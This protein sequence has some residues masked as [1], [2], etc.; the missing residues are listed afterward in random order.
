MDIPL[1]RRAFLQLSGVGL[2]ATGGCLGQ[3]EPVPDVTVSNERNEEI[4]LDLTI[5][6]LSDG[7]TMF[8]GEHTLAN[9]ETVT[10]TN[11]IQQA[12]EFRFDVHV[13]G[14]YEDSYDVAFSTDESRGVEL[15]IHDD[16]LEF[17]VVD[18]GWF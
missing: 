5:S 10:I 4:L 12:G 2:L 8:S 9:Y 17:R 3:A 13:A 1:S 7:A 11:P 15:S 6:R 16:G 18:R 14:L